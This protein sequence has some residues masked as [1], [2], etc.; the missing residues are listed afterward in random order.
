MPPRLLLP[1]LPSTTTTTKMTSST[2][3]SDDETEYPSTNKRAR[4]EGSSIVE[5]VV[6]SRIVS[7]PF[8]DDKEAATDDE[9]ADLNVDMERQ[10]VDIATELDMAT[11]T[12]WQ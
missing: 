10:N 11:V 1:S 7:N 4:S 2:L 8:R 9:E 3:E 12:E 5:V 6:N